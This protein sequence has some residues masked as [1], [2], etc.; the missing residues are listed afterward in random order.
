MT[1]EIKV[2]C[3]RIYYERIPAYLQRMDS[4]CLMQVNYG[5]IVIFEANVFWF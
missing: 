5:L 3:R 2:P 4:R 1:D